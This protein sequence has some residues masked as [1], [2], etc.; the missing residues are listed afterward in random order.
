MLP[1]NQWQFV[2]VRFQVCAV[3]H[4]W[5]ALRQTGRA[6]ART[7]QAQKRQKL[8]TPP[9]VITGITSQKLLAVFNE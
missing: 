7:S 5:L 3:G 9:M 2:S 4:L 8:L 6:L 1:S